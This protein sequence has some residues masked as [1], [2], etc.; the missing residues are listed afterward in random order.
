MAT[1]ANAFPFLQSFRPRPLPLR[2]R[3]LVVRA[4]QQRPIAT[5]ESYGQGD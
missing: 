5:K 2:R 4:V 1:S 3:F